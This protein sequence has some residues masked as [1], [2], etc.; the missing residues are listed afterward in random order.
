[1]TTTDLQTTEPG[2]LPAAIVQSA[3]DYVNASKRDNTRT[4]YAK[5]LRAFEAFCAQHGYAS[6]PATVP[7]VVHYLTGLAD[8]GRK[9]ST[10]ELH[11]S[12]ISFAHGGK[13]NPANPALS[14]EVRTL[15]QGIQ[16]K[17]SQ[18]KPEQAAPEQARPIMLDELRRMAAAAGDGIGGKRDKALLLV[19]WFGAMRRSEIAGLDVRDLLFRNDAVV[20]TLRNSKTDKRGHG[21]V[22]TLPRLSD[23]ELDPVRALR[24]WLEAS[25]RGSGPVFV[26]VDRWG[27]AGSARIND[28][29]VDSVVKRVAARAGL[30]DAPSDYRRISGHSLRAGFA[31]Q[32]ARDGIPD[33]AIMQVTRHNSRVML[34]RYVREGGAAMLDTIRRVAGEERPAG[35]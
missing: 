31:T 8:A 3:R 22:L 14:A 18:D 19:G 6:Q 16:R 34:D 28:K 7:A 2:A 11:R 20:V 29:H 30:A 33:H 10:I 27:H 13:S 23:E 15:T 5:I 9:V 21:Q 32:A 26:R 17:L 12:A 24:T 4:T 35:M 1:M 25:G